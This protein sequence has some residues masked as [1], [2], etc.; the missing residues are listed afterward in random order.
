MV[1]GEVGGAGM[2]LTL[3]GGGL[4]IGDGV[5]DGTE[6]GTDGVEEV[7]VGVEE[8]AK[9]GGVE[10]ML[11][12]WKV[13]LGIAR[14]QTFPRR[15]RVNLVSCPRSRLMTILFSELLLSPR[16]PKERYPSILKTS[17]ETSVNKTKR[18]TP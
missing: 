3:E 18:K 4:E 8:I 9:D 17:S 15:C 16:F 1:G 12:G 6:V 11:E 14:E 7:G 5:E 10:V 2:T 13:D